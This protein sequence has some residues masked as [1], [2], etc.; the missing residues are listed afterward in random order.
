M[1]QSEVRLLQSQ[2]E[3]CTM[4]IQRQQMALFE[5]RESDADAAPSPGKS[6]LSDSI[7]NEQADALRQDK[8]NFEEKLKNFTSEREQ[9]LQAAKKLDKDRARVRGP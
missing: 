5:G 2:L 3:E 4:I 1:D 8:Q 7:L 6:F 9:F